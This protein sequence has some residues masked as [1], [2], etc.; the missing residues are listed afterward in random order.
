MSISTESDE[1]YGAADKAKSDG[2]VQVIAR[3]AKILRALA[4]QPDGLS[5]S[6][7][8]DRVGL[9]RSTV[10]RLIVALENERLVSVAAPHGGYCLG[11][12]VTSLAAASRHGFTAD[13]HGFLSR[14]SRETHESVD[15]SVLE[16]D[17][18]RFVDHI[19]APR[20]LRAVSAVGA[21]F[22]AHCTANGK[23]LLST[24]TDAEIKA[25]LPERLEQLTPHTI[26][27]RSQ[28]L[29]EIA[30]T[31][32]DG[33]AYDREEHTLGICALGAA[34]Q[35]HDGQMAAVAIVLPAQRFYGQ[36]QRLLQ[37]LLPACEEI[38]ATLAQGQ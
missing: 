15:L 7:I 11:P 13:V 31:R 34:I 21:T 12:G 32:R 26:A 33:V 3:A 20:R 24:L 23:M 19:V 9:A 36:E 1:L 37:K 35:D 5:L 2:G 18:I 14:L 38:T 28:L 4:D 30:R 10:H 27:T 22:P 29:E 8:A 17:C 16:H 6:Q 25:L